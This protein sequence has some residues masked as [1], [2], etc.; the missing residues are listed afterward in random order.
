MSRS[1]VCIG[2]FI[3]KY[4]VP[5][6]VCARFLPHHSDVCVVS[7]PEFEQFQNPLKRQASETIESL[8][9]KKPGPNSSA[10][11]L[12]E[13]NN[14]LGE[15]QQSLTISHIESYL[16]TSFEILDSAPNVSVQESSIFMCMSSEFCDAEKVDILQSSEGPFLT[17][18]RSS[19]PL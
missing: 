15:T 19:P 17:T 4:H 18:D 6:E 8:Q 3:E 10:S 13:F 5:D 2:D 11:V 1:I 16:E 12:E 9:L 14:T 7:K